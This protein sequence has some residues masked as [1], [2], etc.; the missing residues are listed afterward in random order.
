MEA[1]KQIA[2]MMMTFMRCTSIPWP[3]GRP[4]TATLTLSLWSLTMGG[5]DRFTCTGS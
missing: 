2:T 4:A 5:A 3:S 1:F